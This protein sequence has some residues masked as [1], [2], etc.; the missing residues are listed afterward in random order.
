M[1]GDGYVDLLL[2][3][4]LLLVETFPVR[5]HL[6]AGRSHRHDEPSWVLV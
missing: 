4:V 6:T 2:E 5:V 3:M 1:W